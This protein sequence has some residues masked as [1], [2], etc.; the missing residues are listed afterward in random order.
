MSIYPQIEGTITEIY[1]NERSITLYFPKEYHDQSDRLFP[2]LLVHDGAELFQD[3]LMEIEENVRKGVAAPVVFA[4]VSSTERNDEYTPWPHPALADKFPAFA[5][6]GVAYLDAIE[7]EII[8]CIQSQYRISMDPLD[9]AIGGAS[10]G[11]LI[12]LYA[13]YKKNHLFKKYMLLSSSLWYEGFIEFMSSEPLDPALQA[14]MY[15]GEKEGITKQNIQRHM[16]ANNKIGYQILCDKLHSPT[17]QLCFETDPEGV[18]DDPYF[19]K[20]FIRG[21]TILFP[22]LT[23]Q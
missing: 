12:S 15:I 8:P 19:I 23:K 16:V 3:V 2:I 6:E 4:G 20:Y 11:G 13:M 7:N 17:K 5:G 10:L 22:G 9:R 1:C 18:H 14:Y 21:L